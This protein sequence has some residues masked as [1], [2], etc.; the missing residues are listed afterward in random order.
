MSNDPTPD[1]NRPTIVLHYNAG[2]PVQY[3]PT[4][5]PA[6]FVSREDQAFPNAKALP[7]CFVKDVRPPSKSHDY[8]LHRD[9]TME[10]HPG[11]NP[12]DNT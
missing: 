10:I 12:P 5:Q 8:L 7:M 4:A 9:G 11:D 2:E 1:N 6:H 3:G